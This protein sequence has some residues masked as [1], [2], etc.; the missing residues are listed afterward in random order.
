MSP[1]EKARATEAQ[2]PLPQT[3]HRSVPISKHVAQ[4][5]HKTVRPNGRCNVL[6]VSRAL[7]SFTPLGG[8]GRLVGCAVTGLGR[9]SPLI[10]SNVG[11]ARRILKAEMAYQLLL[12]VALII[13][14]MGALH[15]FEA[16]RVRSAH[17]RSAVEDVLRNAIAF[18]PTFMTVENARIVGDRLYILI[19]IGDGDGEA[20]MR[21]LS[22]G[23]GPGMD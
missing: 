22:V 19:V 4:S 8:F 1:A 20:T 23:D 7:I 16:R 5:R 15:R 14:A 2:V 9:D 6:T 17:A 21:A 11:G 13:V 18:Q 12:D 3:G 10:L